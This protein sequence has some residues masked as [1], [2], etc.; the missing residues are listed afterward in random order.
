[1]TDS[2]AE[3]PAKGQLTDRLSSP[4]ASPGTARKRAVTLLRRLDSYDHAAYRWVA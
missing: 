1:M 2:N 4:R 3:Q